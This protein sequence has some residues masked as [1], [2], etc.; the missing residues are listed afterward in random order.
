MTPFKVTNKKV[1][2]RNYFIIT[3]ILIIILMTCM[4]WFSINLIKLF[5]IN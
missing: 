2:F 4:F 3:F 1:N 5:L